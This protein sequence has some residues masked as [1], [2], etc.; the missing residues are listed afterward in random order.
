MLIYLYTLCAWSTLF[1]RWSNRPLRA[2]HGD[3][4]EHGEFRCALGDVGTTPTAD[5]LS[6]LLF[7][8]I[9]S[10]SA[11][12]TWVSEEGPFGGTLCLVPFSFFGVWNICVPPENKIV[13]QRMKIPVNKT[14]FFFNKDISPPIRSCQ[15]QITMVWSKWALDSSSWWFCRI[16]DGARRQCFAVTYVA[17]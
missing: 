2:A 9:H 3:C 6:E 13:W 11:G 1:R 15:K 5:R 4:R 7:R 17:F 8:G 12:E 10:C 14:D 16:I